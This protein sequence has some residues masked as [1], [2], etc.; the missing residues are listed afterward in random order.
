MNQNEAKLRK[1]TTKTPEMRHY[2][3]KQEKIFKL[4]MKN[5]MRHY[6]PKGGK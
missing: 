5:K 4:F 1:L 2:K 6:E 3:T